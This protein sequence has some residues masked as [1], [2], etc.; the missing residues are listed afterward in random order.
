M[1]ALWQWGWLILKG[2]TFFHWNFQNII[3][4]PVTGNLYW[5]NGNLRIFLD[6]NLFKW[7]HQW[8]YGESAFE[9]K[10]ASVLIY[11]HLYWYLMKENKGQ[12]SSCYIEKN[13]LC[14]LQSLMGISHRVPRSNYKRPV[15]PKLVIIRFQNDFICYRKCGL[16]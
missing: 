2:N 10:L 1:Y 12:T 7:C 5:L 13:V 8:V 14:W 3:S 9:G 16:Q 11:S 4:F 6:K 15:P